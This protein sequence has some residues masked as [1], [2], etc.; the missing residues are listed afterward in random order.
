[1]S[2]MKWYMH[3]LTHT[4]T[5]INTECNTV[6]QMKQ[7]KLKKQ[8]GASNMQ[9]YRN[10]VLEVVNSCIMKLYALLHGHCT[11]SERNSVCSKHKELTEFVCQP[12]LYSLSYFRGIYL[13]GKVVSGGQIVWIFSL[14][15]NIKTWHSELIKGTQYIMN[16][17]RDYIM[18]M[19]LEICTEKILGTGLMWTSDPINESYLWFLCIDPWL[20]WKIKTLN[21]E[22]S[23]W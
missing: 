18:Q 17:M 22:P 9:W 11:I 12:I 10:L 16:C 6:T 2:C 23:R 20:L 3:A 21:P 1:M 19:P 8:M 13:I 7:N 4:H 15:S 14:T 5:R